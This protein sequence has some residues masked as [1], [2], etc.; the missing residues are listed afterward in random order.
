MI[1]NEILGF[2]FEYVNYDWEKDIAVYNNVTF[3]IDSLE[4]NTGN[5]F[6]R[7]EIDFDTGEVNFYNDTARTFL[8]NNTRT[9]AVMG[10]TYEI[11]EVEENVYISYLHCTFF[12]ESLGRNRGDYEDIIAIDFE[13]CKVS[14]WSDNLKKI[15]D[16]RD[17]K[18]S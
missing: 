10:F 16:T 7:V 2:D 8:Y 5:R 6:D 1:K 9:N 14:F 4:Q 18:L 3:F 17:L 13:N 15:Y 11:A 12:R